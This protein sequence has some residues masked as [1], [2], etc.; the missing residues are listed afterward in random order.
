MN[1]ANDEITLCSAPSPAFL[2]FTQF[3]PS[4]QLPSLRGI[5]ELRISLSY[6]HYKSEGLSL[7]GEQS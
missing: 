5:F 6:V 1:L 3:L 4:S 7:H 2:E